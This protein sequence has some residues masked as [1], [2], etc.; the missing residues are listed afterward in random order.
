MT[1]IWSLRLGSGIQNSFNW[2]DKS[3]SQVVFVLSNYV[4]PF[5]RS[6][7]RGP[8]NQS[9]HVHTKGDCPW[10]KS[11]G[12]DH[13][14]LRIV[15]LLDTSNPF[16][17]TFSSRKTQDAVPPLVWAPCHLER[18]P[19]PPSRGRGCCDHVWILVIRDLDVALRRATKEMNFMTWNRRQTTRRATITLSPAK[20]CLKFKYLG[21]IRFF[22]LSEPSWQKIDS[23]KNQRK[24]I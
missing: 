24:Q 21:F 22:S 11:Q 10:V 9:P 20:C 3:F 6:I 17:T 2:R 16:Q 12:Q 19:R 5:V 14:F 15:T 13:S 18:E 4:C 1:N 23:S 7:S 8:C